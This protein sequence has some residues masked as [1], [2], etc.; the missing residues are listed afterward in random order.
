MDSRNIHRLRLLFLLQF[1]DCLLKYPLSREPIELA[2]LL[3]SHLLHGSE[4]LSVVHLEADLLL[5]GRL[6]SETG[7]DAG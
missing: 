1:Q 6:P 2:H 5:H 4:V 7:V 3:F